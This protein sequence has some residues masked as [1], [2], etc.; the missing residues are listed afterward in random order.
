KR[1]SAI[2]K[3]HDTLRGGYFLREVS[4]HGHG[5]LQFDQVACCRYLDRELHRLVDC[6]SLIAAQAVQETGV[7]LAQFSDWLLC[8]GKPE[9]VST[10]TIGEKLAAAFQGTTFNVTIEEVPS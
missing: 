10:K 9:A 1:F 8:E 6:V 3:F 5:H 2:E 7:C 4:T